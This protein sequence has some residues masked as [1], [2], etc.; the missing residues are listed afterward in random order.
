MD[1][2]RDYRNALMHFREPL[3]TTELNRLRAFAGMLRDAVVA[4]AKNRA[5]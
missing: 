4:M 1:A 2:I 3:G 5:G